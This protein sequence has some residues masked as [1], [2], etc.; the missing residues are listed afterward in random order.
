MTD[1]E[2]IGS[3]AEKLESALSTFGAA[4]E[5][6]PELEP[7]RS[8]APDGFTPQVTIGLLDAN[9]RFKGRRVDADFD[10][11]WEPSECHVLISFAPDLPSSSLLPSPP[12]QPSLPSRLQDLLNALE[13]AEALP[14][15]QFVGL[16]WFRDQYLP[17][18]GFS[19]TADSRERSAQLR[20]A[21]GQG[22]VMTIQVPNPK[23]PSHPTTTIRLN[24]S[25]PRFREKSAP[26]AGGKG[27]FSPRTIEGGPMSQTII[28]GRR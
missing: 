14:G 19:W 24:R 3:F 18:Q 7:L 8:L 21:T 15:L 6:S 27:P 2:T 23:V 17:Q 9:K 26:A 5:L 11:Y 28:E 10:K 20:E 13:H 12:A 25:H 1:R 4:R 22:I 16:K